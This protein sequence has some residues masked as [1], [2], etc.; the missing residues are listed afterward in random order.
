MKQREHLI[1]QID[2]IILVGGSTRIPGVQKLV[3]D[4]FNG[5][6]L[7]KTVHPDE[8]VAYGAAVQ[9]AILAG[10]SSALVRNVVI[11][12]VIPMTLGLD[13]HSGVF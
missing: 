12:D 5:K 2:E 9:A 4:Y 8:A 1:F 13:T 6:P 11:K 7:N 10:N 3:M